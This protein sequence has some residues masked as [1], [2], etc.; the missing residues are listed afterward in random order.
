MGRT[1]DR[2]PSGCDGFTCNVS[3]ICLCRFCGGEKKYDQGV[4]E[5]GVLMIYL[6]CLC[7]PR[8][9]REE[10]DKVFNFIPPLRRD[11][12]FKI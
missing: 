10:L 12:K 3:N 11:I 4:E 8:G 6:A 1:S 7:D 5:E 2:S 9:L